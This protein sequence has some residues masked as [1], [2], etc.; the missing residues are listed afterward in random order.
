M[1]KLILLAVVLIVVSVAVVD[2]YPRPTPDYSAVA[3]DN[4]RS[5]IS[6]L[7]QLND[8]YIMILDMQSA[9][10]QMDGREQSDKTRLI[11]EMKQLFKEALL[12]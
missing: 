9:E 7:T 12:D 10:S 4:M 1:T 3:Q 2:S 6:R 11:A 8:I 5:C